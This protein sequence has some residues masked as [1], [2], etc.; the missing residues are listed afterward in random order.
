MVS[1]FMCE[2]ISFDGKRN[3][4]KKSRPYRVGLRLLCA[5]QLRPALRNSPHMLRQSSLFSGLS[6]QCSTIQKGMGR[7]KPVLLRHTGAGRYPEIKN[8]IPAKVMPE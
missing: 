5:L 6:L 3:E 2:F 7:S 4:P 8:W 1:H